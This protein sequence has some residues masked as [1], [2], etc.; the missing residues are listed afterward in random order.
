[1]QEYVFITDSQVSKCS[2]VRLSSNICLLSAT[3]GAPSLEKF[4]VNFMF[5]IGTK[6]H[7]LQMGWIL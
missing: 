5:V 1:M 4:F 3:E 6:N 7:N 2:T